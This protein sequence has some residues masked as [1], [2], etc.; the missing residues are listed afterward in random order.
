M[1]KLFSKS[2]KNNKG[3]TLI[4]LVVVIAVLGILAAVAVPRFG[5][6]QSGAKETAD[7]ATAKSLAKA[8]ELAIA[9]GNISLPTDSSPKSVN[10]ETDLV[11]NGYLDGKPTPQSTDTTGKAFEIEVDD[12]GTISVYINDDGS[13]EINTG[14]DG[15]D[16]KVYP[17][18]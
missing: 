9:E 10:I 3:F 4:E 16:K 8:T 12:D 5:N 14:A 15:S 17:T 6:F 1:I 11:D 18:N 7:F 13:G 2:L